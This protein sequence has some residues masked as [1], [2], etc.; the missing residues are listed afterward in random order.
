MTIVEALFAVWENE[1]DDIM[2]ILEIESEEI[3]KEESSSEATGGEIDA[4]NIDKDKFCGSEWNRSNGTGIKKRKWSSPERR[5]S[6]NEKVTLQSIM[7]SNWSNII[8]DS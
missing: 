2:E 1:E 7:N 8:P 5:A 6:K 4:A 3:D